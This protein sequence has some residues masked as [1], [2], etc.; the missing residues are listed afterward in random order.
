MERF[1]DYVLRQLVDYPD[2]ILILKEEVPGKTI[3]KVRLASTDVGRIVGRS[4][5]MIQALRNLLS[6]AA[7]KKGERVLLE[8]EED[9]R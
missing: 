2:E 9:R 8:I 1:L 6:A 3:Y 5:T 4:G 7:E